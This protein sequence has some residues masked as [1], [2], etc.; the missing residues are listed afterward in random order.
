VRGDEGAALEALAWQIGSQLSDTQVR[1]QAARQLLVY[2]PSKASELQV[3]SLYR[4]PKGTLDWGSFLTA[5]ELETRARSLLDLNLGSSAVDTLDAVAAAKRDLDWHLLRARGLTLAHR[6]GEALAL[7]VERQGASPRENQQLEWERASAAADAG[8]ARSGSNLNA[9]QRQTLRDYAQLRFEKVAQIGADPALAA[10]ALRSLYAD[11]MSDERFERGLD[12][13]RRL[14]KMDPKDS[15]GAVYLWQVGWREYGRGNYSGAVGYWTE[16]YAL[17]P[18]TSQ[19]RSGRYWTARAFE[20]LGENERA[21]QIF[22]EVAQADTSDFYRRNAQVR[23][24]SRVAA[25]AAAKAVAPRTEAWPKESG[26]YRAHLLT[27]LGLDGLALEESKA[28]GAKVD[29]KAGRALEAVILAR[30]GQYRDS[31]LAIRDA[32]TSLGGP[33]QATVPEEARRLYYPIAY[34]EN[35]RSAAKTNRLP[36]SLVYGVI[37]Q[38]SAFDL[39]ARS[40]AG[41][42]GLMQLMPATGRELAGKMGGQRPAGDDLP[43]PGPRHVRRQSRAFAGRLQRWSVPH[44]APVERV[45]QRRRGRPLRRKPDPFRADHLRE[46]DPRPL[47]Q[48][49]PALPAAGMNRGSAFSRPGLSA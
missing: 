47:R 29:R 6:G 12:I 40:R 18:E 26:L 24:G 28:I 22:G 16:L 43:A 10:K 5:D 42:A 15:T 31:V 46:E 3:A 41:A 23:L 14:R 17:Y 1:T 8:I 49:S 37:R 33:F 39:K 9:A 34:E 36:V 48:L 35:I 11:E 19:G 25:A 27:D 13:L 4:S 44:Q 21:L 20:S 32:F 38:E 2:F 7:L 45:R 30:K